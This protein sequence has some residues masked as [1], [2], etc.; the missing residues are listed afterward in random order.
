MKVEKV[1]VIVLPCS[2]LN[3][4]FYKTRLTLDKVGFKDLN[5]DELE[6]T[7]NICRWKL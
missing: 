4:D 3:I 1:A 6:K 5:K 2:L 7:F